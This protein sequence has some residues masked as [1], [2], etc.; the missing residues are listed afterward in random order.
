EVYE[1][2]RTLFAAQFIGSPAM[3][4]IDA[5]IQGGAVMIGEQAVAEASAPDGPVK[6][7]IRPE[8]MN[9]DD[10]GPL[11]VAVQM[12]EPLGA[13]TLLHG[14]LPGHADSFTISLPGVHAMPERD[15]PLRF[16]V[17]KGQSHIFDP[18][19]GLRLA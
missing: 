14:R 3:N 9:P 19:T 7:G 2:P 5:H 17:Q 1:S 11:S 4:V 8:H 18:T 15:A 10:N 13:N 12:T 6:F 16:S